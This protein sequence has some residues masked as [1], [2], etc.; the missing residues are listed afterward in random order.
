MTNLPD[1]SAYGYEVV[2]E[3]GLNRSGGRVTYQAQHLETGQPAVIKQFQFVKTGNSWSQ[4]DCYQQEIQVLRG[5]NH[6]GIPRYLE[7]FQTPDGFC[8]VQEYKHAQPLSVP[9]SF[10]PEEV[11]QIAIAVLDILVYLQNRIPPV[12]H[13]D[14]KPEN[15]LVDDAINVYLVDFGFA[16]I[17]DG[18]VAVSSVVK[19]TMGFMPPEQLFNRELTE[20]SDL[21]GLGATLICL[22]T[23]TKSIDVGSLLDLDHRFHFQHLVAKL[24]RRWVRWLEKMVEP[25]PK[26][27]FANALT[28]LEALQPIPVT[29]LPEAQLSHASVVLQAQGLGDVIHHTMTIKNA[30]ATRQVLQG[31]WEVAAHTSDP[32]H[33]PDRHSWIRVEPSSFVG[34]E[35]ECQIVIDTRKLRAAN[36]YQR[37]LLLHTNGL[38]KTYCVDLRVETAPLPLQK[39]HVPYALVGLFGAVALPAAWVGVWILRIIEQVIGNGGMF[40]LIVA[41]SSVLGFYVAAGILAFLGLRTGAIA[42]VVAGLV[43]ILGI[44]AILLATDPSTGVAEELTL[45]AVPAVVGGGLGMVLAAIAGIGLGITTEQLTAKQCSQRFAI[46]L[47]LSTAALAASISTGLIFGWLQPG[48]LIGLVGSGLFFSGILGYR[49]L[50]NLRWMTTY[51]QSERYLIKP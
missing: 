1:F 40:S 24:N 25:R 28:A 17:G 46:A 42:N 31:T 29:P 37:Q 26:D 3:I 27:R 49:L 38:P 15:I 34:N 5:L 32:P 10:D 30:I 11:K 13:R 7:S 2:R 51:R 44:I 8:M 47:T 41:L 18:E 48:V 4:Y 9:R 50:A 36:T 19:G 33:T 43:G 12:I 6:S 22:L 23:Q 20:A 21:Y 45:T 35:A 39:F 16:R 14:I